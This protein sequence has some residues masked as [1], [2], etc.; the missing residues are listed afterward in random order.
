M[1]KRVEPR[2]IASTLKNEPSPI[3]LIDLLE[4]DSEDFITMSSLRSYALSNL[5]PK[6][7]IK[8]FSP[9]DDFQSITKKI[10]DYYQSVKIV[11]ESEKQTSIPTWE[12]HKPKVKGCIA[13]LQK[14]SSYETDYS[15]SIKVFGIGG[16]VNK[17]RKVGFKDTIEAR[18]ECLQVRLPITI[19]L[20]RCRTKTGAEFVRTNVKDIGTIPSTVELKG[21]TDHCGVSFDRIVKSPWITHKFEVAPATVHKI[22]LSVESSQGVELD[23]EPKIPG[24]IDLSMKVQ[25]KLEKE[26]TY[27]YELV[28]PHCYFAYFPKNSIAWYWGVASTPTS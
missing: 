27:S 19:V 10:K 7:A 13:T 23:L 18:G 1:P 8:L 12:I 2:L 6:E 16:G 24:I 20:Q 21:D 26:I 15:L 28:G 17:S 5:P 11:D 9:K 4:E 14:S 25:L 22:E 3:E